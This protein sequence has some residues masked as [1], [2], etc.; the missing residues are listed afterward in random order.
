MEEYKAGEKAGRQ[1]EVLKNQS[2]N[3]GK[4]TNLKSQEERT[5]NLSKNWNLQQQHKTSKLLEIC[6][7][8]TDQNQRSPHPNF[9]NKKP[10]LKTTKHPNAFLKLS[11]SVVSSHETII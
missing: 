1:Q 2:L 9:D 7:H 4:L 3:K 5:N 10:H 11:Y 6:P 8:N